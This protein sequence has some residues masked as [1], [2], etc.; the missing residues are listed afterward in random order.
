[1]A[2]KRR[3]SNWYIYLLTFISA[4][5][6]AGMFLSVFWDVIFVPKEKKDFSGIKSD[7]PDAT[8]NLITLFM[9]SEEKAANPSLY[10]IVS[11]QP[12]DETIICIPVKKNTNFKVGNK[13]NTADGWYS[14]G[15]IQ[16]VLYGVENTFGIKCDRYVK[17]DRDSFVEL[18]DSLGKVFV[19]CA[20]DVL[21]N[22]GAVVF[23]AGGHSMNGTNL[24]T[25]MNYNNPQYGEDYQSLAVGSAIVS[26]INSNLHGLSA[27]VIQS[28]FTK[29]MN[30]TDNNLTIDDY[31]KRQQALL[32]TSAETFKPG[33]YYIPYGETDEN[34]NFNLSPDSKAT[35]LERLKYNM[36]E[37]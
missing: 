17:S 27:I 24:Y 37:E 31:T 28:H 25:Y 13:I 4:S 35:I 6:L 30:T 8:N 32:F 15:G 33:Q 19:N 34:G 16:S 36:N 12:A 20:Y 10:T 14:E 26:L 9:L 5:V 18:T 7:A 3:K 22:D 1:M 29:L 2:V 23:E 11:F 21:A